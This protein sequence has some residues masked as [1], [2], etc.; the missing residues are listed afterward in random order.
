MSA[1]KVTDELKHPAVILV[2]SNIQPEHNI[3]LALN[4]L[5]QQ[6]TVELVSGAW[7][8]PAVGSAGPNYINLAV[9]IQTSLDFDSLKQD[10]LKKIEQQL[11]RERGADKYAPRTIDLDII[12]FRGAVID[13]SLWMQ[14]H[15]A[16]PV[17][18]LCPELL[19]PDE[20]CSLAVSAEVLRQE[21]G[22]IRHPGFNV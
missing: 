1:G 7:V 8:T 12:L 5:R 13:E 17:S 11:G 10:I 6:V 18:E 14:A 15:V 20:C 2:G 4:R 22:A 16:L 21:S 9:L 19:H 3:S